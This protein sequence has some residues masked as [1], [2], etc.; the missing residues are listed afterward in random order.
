M[1]RAGSRSLRAYVAH[2][3]SKVANRNFNF[4]VRHLLVSEH[5]LKRLLHIIIC[6]GWNCSIRQ[7]DPSS[8]NGI[9][10]ARYIFITKC[11]SIYIFSKWCKCVLRSFSTY[12]AE[13]YKARNKQALYCVIIFHVLIV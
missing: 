4:D 6:R 2:I 7:G 12:D 13:C 9:R 8:S 11:K 5:T 3:I 10:I 1:K